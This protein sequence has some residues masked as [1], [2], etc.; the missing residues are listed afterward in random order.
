MVMKIL[1]NSFSPNFKFFLISLSLFFLLSTTA[2]ASTNVPA[3]NVSG[4]WNLA[5]SPYL[6][7]GDITVVSGETLIIEPGVVVEFQNWYRLIVNGNIQ[8]I[9][10]SSQQIVFTATPP[11]P[12]EPG[13]PGIDFIDANSNSKL[14]YCVIEN[15]QSIA[16]EPNDRGG[17]VYMLNS[18]PEIKNCTMR[19]FRV[20]SY[21][22]AIYCDN[23][24]PLI[25]GC[26]INR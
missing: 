4:T 21:G 19:N 15:G 5:S 18:S 22:A 14:E 25:E 26:T 20:K 7:N 17:A 9:G 1:R 8:A 16:A 10:T 6:I 13:W 2:K 24:N 12:G 3:G 11:G 23:S